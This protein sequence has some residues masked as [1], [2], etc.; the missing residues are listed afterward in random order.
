MLLPARSE[1][2]PSRRWSELRHPPLRLAQ[3][4]A[5]PP[6]LLHG[7]HRTWRITT[8]PGAPPGSG[9]VKVAPRT[10]G[11]PAFDPR[12]F[13]DEDGLLHTLARHGVPRVPRVYPAAPGL[14]THG[15]IEGEPLSRR[16][17]PGTAPSRRQLGHI[18]TLFGRLA[19]IGP[20]DLDL[21]HRCPV[22]R[23]PRSS[24]GFLA[25][26]LRFTRE[27]VYHVH[28]PTL[29]PLFATLRFDPALLAPDGL[30]A[31]RAAHLAD[32]P[33]A[34]LHGDLH[35]DNLIVAADGGGLWTIDWELALVGDPLYDL[36]T[37]LHLMR[38]P[39]GRERALAARWARAVEAARPGA[40]ARWE[41][42]LPH[43][44]AYKRVQSVVTDVIRQAR[45]V[46]AS[47]P[48]LRPARLA[49]A[50]G[51]VTPVLHRAGLATS[52]TAGDVEAA[53]AATLPA[54]A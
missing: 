12:C 42:D 9:R 36:A 27:R 16:H 49:A 5:D 50:A 7:H 32:R 34:L 26:L 41:R 46:S 2:R 17:P 28:A 38:Y 25:A 33:F 30:L 3:P 24:G 44:L 11:A 18:V 4:P 15:Y 47:P 37:H 52:L 22:A 23:R 21:L 1:P 14:Q 8:A 35:R 54:A 13:D 43:Y 53:Y 51:A 39:P 48:A 10:H 31:H 20:A 6:P 29:E 40:S 45:S 19:R